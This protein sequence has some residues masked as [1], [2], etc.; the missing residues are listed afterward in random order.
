MGGNDAHTDEYISDY[1][2]ESD[3]L[4]SNNSK[5][6]LAKALNSTVIKYDLLNTYK[7]HLFRKIKE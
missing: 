4:S 1:H 7:S 2:K 6:V 5:Q 3:N